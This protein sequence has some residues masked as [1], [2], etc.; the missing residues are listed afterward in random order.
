MKAHTHTED[1][2]QLYHSAPCGFITITG[3]GSIVNV[4]DTLLRWLGYT[5]DQ[6][7]GQASLQALLD[8][9]GKI[10]FETHI[11]PML[12]IEG[13]VS[14]INITMRS[15]NKKNRIPCLLNAVRDKS[16]DRNTA[17]FHCV[18][19]K[20]NHRKLY[21][22]E[23]LEARKE[24]ERN[25]QKLAQ[26]NQDLERF[27]HTASHD[28]QAPLNTIYGLMNLLE[29]QGYVPEDSDGAQYFKLIKGN[30]MRMKLM[31]HDLLDYAKLDAE[32][33]SFEQVSLKEACAAALEMLGEQIKTNQAECIVGELPVVNGDRMKLIRLFQNIIGNAIKYRS[34]AA[35]RIEISFVNKPDHVTVYISDNGMGFDQR[36]ADDIFGFMKR[37]HS[38][39]SISGSGI[40]LSA[41]KR[42]I[43][44]HGGEIGATSEP[45]AGSAFFFTLPK[46][47]N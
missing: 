31:I 20:M 3:D 37:L 43:D 4:N 15:A 36:F 11:M 28:L 10:Y 22:I 6:L 8:V 23:L 21:E 38:H 42:I 16:T 17:I 13:E 14:E 44:L 26:I 9:G 40:G 41:C 24:A 2:E 47:D 29:R 1:F 45:G 19:I 12:Q 35:P 5:R 32:E 30:A 7:I 25:V 33:R 27:A 18:V 46:P 39:D 34:E